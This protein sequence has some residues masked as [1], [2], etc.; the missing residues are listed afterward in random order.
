VVTGYD[1]GGRLW[2]FCFCAMVPVSGF[3]YFVL[4]FFKR[5]NKITK[6]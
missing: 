1:N 4:S 2:L 6:A 5:R 3:D